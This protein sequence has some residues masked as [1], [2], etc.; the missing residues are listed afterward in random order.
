M[1]RL[2]ATGLLLLLA[3]VPLFAQEK[4]A[5][6]PPPS[7]DTSA[8]ADA[9][10]TSATPG[11]K[12]ALPS[13][14]EITRTLPAEPGKEPQLNE[15]EIAILNPETQEWEVSEFAISESRHSPADLYLEGGYG[16]MTALTL[17]LIA[18][19]F[20]TWKAPRWIK[21]ARIAGLHSRSVEYDDRLLLHSPNHPDNRILRHIHAALGR[22]ARGVHRSNLRPDYLRT[23]AAAAHRR[24]T[25]HLTLRPVRVVP[26]TSI[27]GTTRTCHSKDES[28]GKPSTSYRTPAPDTHRH[29][30][31]GTGSMQ[32]PG[33]ISASPKPSCRN[34]DELPTIRPHNEQ[35]SNES[36][37]RIAATG[38][39]TCSGI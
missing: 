28:R 32:N 22:S 31:R 39:S 13:A 10:S 19:L 30:P 20:C 3:S 35:S 1:K 26:G 7:A 12:T 23:V 38:R 33:Q 14:Q 15:H 18:M 8:A 27:F 2:L 29:G 11:E 6:V 4:V 9:E 34:T 5:I 25:A 24:K 36:P 21:E 16:W 17:C 37:D